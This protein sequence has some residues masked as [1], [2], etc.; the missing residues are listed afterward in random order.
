MEKVRIGDTTYP[1]RGASYAGKHVIK[2]NFYDEVPNEFGDLIILTESG[3]I[4]SDLKGFNTVWKKE[5]TAVWLS[6]NKTVYPDDD[7]VDIGITD[8]ET[9]YQKLAQLEEKQA[10]T[11]EELTNAQLALTELAAMA[12]SK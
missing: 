3:D 6:D 11:E 12:A 4:S 7:T 10:S 2:I 5:G 9:V 8:G 1:I